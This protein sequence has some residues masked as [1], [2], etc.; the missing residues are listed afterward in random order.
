MRPR[1]GRSG[2]LAHGGGLPGRPSTAWGST[3]RGAGT[4]RRDELGSGPVGGGR[5]GRRRGQSGSGRSVGDIAGVY[6][7]VAADLRSQQ[8]DDTAFG[9][10][11][12]GVDQ[13][14]DEVAIAVAPPQQDDVSDVAEVV[15]DQLGA[16]HVFDVGAKVVVAVLVPAELLDDLAG[17]KPE[18]MR[19]AIAL[20]GVARGL[21]HRMSSRHRSAPAI[22]GA[23]GV[24]HP[25]GGTLR[26]RTAATMTIE[27][28]ALVGLGRGLDG[29]VRTREHQ[30]LVAVVEPDE[31]GRTAFATPNLDDLPDP[32]SRADGP[33]VN[34]QPVTD[35]RVH[36]FTSTL[37]ACSKPAAP[38]PIDKAPDVTSPPPA[39]EDG[40]RRPRKCDADA[41]VPE[42]LRTVVAA[43]RSPI[44]SNG[45][46]S[47]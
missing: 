45:L 20:V 41:G 11:G 46:P 19:R 1:R 27:V 10:V 18:P 43:D 4:L 40:R 28:S 24:V 47:Q 17:P 25:R 31:V 9:E 38:G 23:V 13:R 6:V 2:Y 16:R 12:L 22:A 26:K 21:A 5:H 32:I 35:L 44:I 36:G 29:R 14:V 8:P 42:P 39:G 37:A 33:A 3:P 7:P 30:S 15:L 34:V